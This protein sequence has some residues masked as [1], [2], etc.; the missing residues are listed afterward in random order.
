MPWIPIF[1]TLDHPH[2]DLFKAIMLV[3]FP[4]AV[5]NLIH[6]A[7]MQLTNT[8]L[9]LLAGLELIWKIWGISCYQF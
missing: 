1:V 2:R 7:R 9:L 5:L 6:R 3:S 8:L 4:N